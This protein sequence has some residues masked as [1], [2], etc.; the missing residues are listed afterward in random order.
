LA[1]TLH[2]GAIVI[3]IVERSLAPTTTKSAARRQFAIPDGNN[4]YNPPSAT[5]E[6]SGFA[7]ASNPQII[8]AAAIARQCASVW[9]RQRRTRV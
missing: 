1:E 2:C 6:V 5:A 7:P 8:P 3:A 4:S 9:V